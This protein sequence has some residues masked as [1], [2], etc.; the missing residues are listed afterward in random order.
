MSEESYRTRD[1]AAEL[2]RA[3]SELARLRHE[4]DALDDIRMERDMLKDELGLLQSVY[5]AAKD[6]VWILER[7]LGETQGKLA[8]TR[9]VAEQLALAAQ[10]QIL[11]L[12]GVV[13]SQGSALRRQETYIAHLETRID[14]MIRR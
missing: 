10:I 3:E 1:W 7:T 14:K 12:E 13:K 2:E 4:T 9:L 5:A 6:Q 11:Q 8:A